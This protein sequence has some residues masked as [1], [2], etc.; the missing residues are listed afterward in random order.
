MS[1]QNDAQKMKAIEEQLKYGAEVDE[2]ANVGEH[3]SFLGYNVTVKNFTFRDEVKARKILRDF[4]ECDIDD[5]AINLYGI[6]STPAEVA[7]D[8]IKM[9][10]V[11]TQSIRNTTN[12]NS[13]GI[14]AVLDR[15]D[16]TSEEQGRQLLDIYLRC[17]MDT[18]LEQL[19]ADNAYTGQ[20]GLVAVQAPATGVTPNT[21]VATTMVGGVSAFTLNIN[22]PALD[23]T[24]LHDKYRKS[25]AGI[26]E[27]DATI[28]VIFDPADTNI[29]QDEILECLDAT[30]YAG[31]LAADGRIQITFMLD[32]D[33][34]ANQ[35]IGYSGKV[36]VVGL[37]VTSSVDDVV[38]AT[39]TLQGDGDLVFNKTIA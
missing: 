17:I 36:S 5:I 23:T 10:A 34:P 9:A 6:N 2:V 24:A 20:E 37:N 30:Q 14:D 1:N 25:V 16:L 39:F 26:K 15:I 7:D 38:R 32:A 13:I 33:K 12:N 11:L 8:R 21:P 4:D 35:K 3:I 31:T 19:E 29:N 22:A 18:S 27:W 28:D